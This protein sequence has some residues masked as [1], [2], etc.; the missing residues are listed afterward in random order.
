MRGL[1]EQQGI[2]RTVLS[3]ESCVTSYGNRVVSLMR[4]QSRGAL[5]GI[6][7]CHLCL[8]RVVRLYARIKSCHLCGNR[9]V[10]L[11][12]GME[13]CDLCVNRVVPL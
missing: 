6:E 5:S 11:Y 4:E 13:P 7:P 1:K 12:T 9:V 2:E 10:A 8:N 3:I